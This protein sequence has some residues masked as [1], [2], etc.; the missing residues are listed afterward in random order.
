M[1][2]LQFIDEQRPFYPVQQLCQVLDVVPSRF[3]AWRLRQAA[4]AAGKAELVWETEMVAVLTTTNATTARAGYR[5]SS[6]KRAT[7]WAARPYAWDYDGTGGKCCSPSSL[8]HAPPIRPTGNAARL[9]CCSTSPSRP[10]PTGCGSAGLTCLPLASGA[11]IV[12]GRA[13]RSRA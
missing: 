10:R 13:L 1:S 5:P 6:E 11:W 9:T 4:A 8:F 3:Y 7:E 12:P 2:T